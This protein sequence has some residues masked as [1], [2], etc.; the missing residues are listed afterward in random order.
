HPGRLVL[1]SAASQRPG[2]RGGDPSRLR[3]A[4]QARGD[5]LRRGM[6]RPAPRGPLERH[7]LAGAAAAR[8]GRRGR[9]AARAASHPGALAGAHRRRR[10]MMRAALCA[11]LVAGCAAGPDFH[12]PAPPAAD[13]GAELPPGAQLGAELPAQWWA[14]YRSPALGALVERSLAANPSIAQ[15]EAALRV[16]Q[17]TQLAQRGALLPAAEVSYGVARAKS[18]AVLSPP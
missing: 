6:R 10:R 4:A 18:A 3:A 8:A 16:A 12:P 17:E 7:R 14:L 13:Y 1:R 15:A 2:A 9:H 5:D 11:L